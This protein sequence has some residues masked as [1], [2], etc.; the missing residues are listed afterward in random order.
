MSLE[1]RNWL[2]RICCINKWTLSKNDWFSKVLIGYKPS[3]ILTNLICGSYPL[4]WFVFL[5]IWVRDQVPDF[6]ICL[7]TSFFQKTIFSYPSMFVFFLFLCENFWYIKE[8]ISLSIICCKYIFSVCQLSMQSCYQSF[9]SF[10]FCDMLMK[11]FTIPRSLKHSY[12]FPYKT[13]TY[14]YVKDCN[15]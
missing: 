13:F 12:L 2:V 5:W 8:I 3:T 11:S 10:W 1:Y 15:V 14:V 4:F 7:S 6:W 9:P